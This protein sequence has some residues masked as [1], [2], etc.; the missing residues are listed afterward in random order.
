MQAWDSP[1]GAV[2]KTPPSIAGGVGS[3]TGGTTK[4]PHV[5][6]WGQKFFLKKR[7]M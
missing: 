4:I 5:M 3:I 2:V 7:E 1:S 6:V